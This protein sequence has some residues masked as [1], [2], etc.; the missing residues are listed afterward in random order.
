MNNQLNDIRTVIQSG[1]WGHS[2]D[3]LRTLNVIQRTMGQTDNLSRAEI[4]RRAGMSRQQ[5]SHWLDA[6]LLEVKV[7][8]NAEIKADLASLHLIDKSMQIALSRKRVLLKSK[9]ELYD[10]FKKRYASKY[11]D[12]EIK[13]IFRWWTYLLRTNLHARFYKT[14]IV[15]PI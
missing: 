12:D 1:V 5:V 3:K 14:Q 7:Y 10:V 6:R 2:D 8:N 4:A 9:A 13:L 15:V 11:S